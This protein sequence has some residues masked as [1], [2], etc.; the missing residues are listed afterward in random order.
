MT[1]RNTLCLLLIGCAAVFCI[2]IS[3]AEDELRE[4]ALLGDPKSEF[5][6]GNEYFYGT[7]TRKANPVLAAH[8]FRKAA[9]E[10]PEAMYNYGF[11]LE[12]GLG[13]DRDPVA[14]AECY[15]KAAE[16]KCEAAEYKYALVLLNGVEF[17]TVEEHSKFKE[18]DIP[19]RDP[20]K[21]RKMIRS[22]AARGYLPAQVELAAILIARPADVSAKDA[23]EA[24]E[25]VS[26]AVK[27]PDAPPRAWRVLA[28]CYFSGL[29]T[30]PDGKKMIEALETAVAK[31]NLESLSRMGYCYEFGI[32]VKADPKKALACYERAAKAGL[33]AAMLKYGDMIAAGEVEGKGTDDALV[34]LKRSA[35]EDC[36]EALYR[37]GTWNLNGIGGDKDPELAAELFSRGAQLEHPAC[38]YELGML[39]LKKDGPI[40]KDEK[41]A[42]FWF[43]RAASNGSAPA[44][45]Q[46]AVCCE[47]GIGCDVDLEKAL[48]LYREA[49][50]N[51]DVEA[52]RRLSQ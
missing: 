46:L 33:P 8:W 37:L 39:F 15:R 18:S 13:V 10:I 6:L 38:Q 44:Q 48:A 1:G 22:L 50:K 14:A 47:N 52:R 12:N 26:K 5:A 35:A 20:E 11:C 41:A 40:A 7:E 25:L 19:A 28:D 21:G 43:N 24:F 29:G 17:R 34:W 3:A 49:A 23:E 36:P 42:F 16:K 45:R 30:V 51:G 32:N 2:R 9:D 27:N 31:G 4:K